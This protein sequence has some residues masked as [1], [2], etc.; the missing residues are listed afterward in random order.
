MNKVIVLGRICTEL[1]LRYSS[2]DEKSAVGKFRIAV[3]R[4]FK[5]ED[6]D[7]DFFQC[8]AFSSTAELI[9]KYFHKGDRILLVGRLEVNE[10]TNKEGKKVNSTQIIVEEFSFV[11]P[12]KQEQKTEDTGFMEIP[13][14][15]L[16]FNF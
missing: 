12:K 14:E 15:D 2:S 16:P 5:K 13:E 1:E 6:A 11:E 9:A 7:T 4:R 3:P 8:T 10:Y